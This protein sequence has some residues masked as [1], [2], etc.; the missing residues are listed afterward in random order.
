MTTSRSTTSSSRWR[1]ATPSSS[2]RRCSTEPGPTSQPTCSASR[3]CCRSPPRSAGRWRP[4][5]ATVWSAPSTR[6]PGPQGGGHPGRRA[7]ARPGRG[8][9]GLPVPDQPGPRPAGRRAH[10]GLPGRDRARRPRRRHPAR[11]A[12]GPARRV[13]RPARHEQAVSL[14]D[15]VV[16]VSGGT[17]G[18]GAAVARAAVDAGATVAVSGRREDVGTVLAEELEQRGTARRS[19]SR[20]TSPTWSRRGPASPR[21]YAGSAGSTAWSTRPA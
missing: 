21:W 19:S 18:V 4:S 14:Q 2:T 5:T 11:G 6:A 13:R 20:P 3:T 17:Q 7:R 15:K 12:G 9:R 1:R 8:G 10:P 16:L